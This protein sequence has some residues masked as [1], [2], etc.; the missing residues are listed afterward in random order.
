[1]SITNYL[2]CAFTEPGFLPRSFPSETINTEKV[3]KISTDSG[4]KTIFKFVN[5]LLLNQSI[6]I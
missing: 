2:K 6:E 3:N 5:I 4:G 1:M